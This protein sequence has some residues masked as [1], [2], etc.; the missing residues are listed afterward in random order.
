MLS[1]HV[2]Y[3]DKSN[4]EIQNII[5]KTLSQNDKIMLNGGPTRSMDNNSIY[6]SEQ[7]SVIEKYR[8]YSDIMTKTNKPVDIPVGFIDL[9][10]AGKNVDTNEVLADIIVCVDS[11]YRGLGIGTQLINKAIK[12]FKTQKNLTTLTYGCYVENK[13]SINLAIKCGFKFRKFDKRRNM[14]LLEYKK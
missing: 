8:I 3:K 11:N 10:Y 1:H 12:W 13:P 2:I 6:N 9:W 14:I 4:V 7:I 5:Y